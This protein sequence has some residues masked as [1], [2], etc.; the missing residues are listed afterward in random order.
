MNKKALFRALSFLM[1]ISIVLTFCIIPA[2]AEA[3]DTWEPVLCE[4]GFLPEDAQTAFDTALA[5]ADDAVYTPVA[6][7]STQKAAGTNYCILCRIS[8]KKTD[9]SPY[10]AL[11]YLA[12]DLQGNAE[13]TNVYELYIARHAYPT[14]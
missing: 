13:V 3:E 2:G 10:W 11:V 9:F 6:L 8:P 7:L 14:N 12:A 5:A 1:L 4:A